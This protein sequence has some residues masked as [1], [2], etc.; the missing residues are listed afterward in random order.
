MKTERIPPRIA[1]LLATEDNTNALAGVIP[2]LGHLLEHNK[3]TE[4]AYLC[5]QSAVQ[6]SKLQP[7]EGQFCGYRNIQMLCLTLGTTLEATS[8]ARKQL[9]AKLTIPQLQDMIEAAWNRS[10][11][12]CGRVQL[13]GGIKGT[14]K[15]IGTSEVEALLLNLGVPCLG[16]AYKG[17]SAWSEV[18]DFVEAYFSVGITAKMGVHVTSR[19]PIFLQRPKHSITVVGIERSSDGKRA[20]LAF[21]PAWSP[22]ALLRRDAL[23]CAECAGWKAKWALRQYRKTEGYLKRWQEFETVCVEQAPRV[24]CWR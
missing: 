9:G 6:V 12:V 13:G 16:R 3:T 20:L 18:L 8:P 23:A 24:A 7:T 11:N 1:A 19:P 10:Y 15:Y 4:I 5:D 21:D 14:A 2:K 22:P 17:A